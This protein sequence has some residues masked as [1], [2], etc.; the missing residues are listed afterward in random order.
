MQHFL[1]DW[2]IPIALVKLLK[3]FKSSIIKLQSIVKGNVL[4]SGQVREYSFIKNAGL[5]AWVLPEV[6]S[7]HQHRVAMSEHKEFNLL[8]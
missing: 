3:P 7:A 2:K 5:P 1:F 6:Q 8:S 4:N